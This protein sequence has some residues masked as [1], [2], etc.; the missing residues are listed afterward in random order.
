MKKCVYFAFH[1][2]LNEYFEKGLEVAVRSVRF[3]NPH[4]PVFV[5]H[6]GFS[7]EQKRKLNGCEFIKIDPSYL[8]NDHRGDLTV[9]AY[10]KL[11]VE[12]LT[13]FDRVL[14]LDSDL[15]V[16][17]D[18]EPIF[19]YRGPVAA[20]REMYTLAH[21][22]SD[23]ESVK[24]RE[25]LTDQSFFLNSGVMLLDPRYWAAEKILDQCFEIARSYGWEFF[26][27]AD[28]GILN[29]LFHRYGRFTE[30][31]REYNYCLWPDMACSLYSHTIKNKRN[32]RA[33]VILTRTQ[34][35]LAAMGLPGPWKRG[36]SARVV[37]WNGREKPWKNESLED[38]KVKY[39]RSV[40]EQF[41]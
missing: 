20:R 41:L 8:T 1:G 7:D 19:S 18:L 37:H 9:G 23:P 14:Y 12:K 17:D 15:V 40:Y 2:G 3:T 29:I 24:R 33:P 39:Y 34:Q 26:K 30:L 16:L 38:K 27:N 5:L 35:R 11:F 10:F 31:P 25:G 4:L 32:L 22:F 21:E 36:V 28:Q 13:D 6:D